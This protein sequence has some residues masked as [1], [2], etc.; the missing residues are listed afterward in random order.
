MPDFRFQII[1]IR[2]RQAE[3]YLY[4]LTVRRLQLL[5][6]RIQY[7]NVKGIGSRYV[8]ALLPYFSYRGFYLGSRNCT[9]R[10]LCIFRENTGIRANCNGNAIQCPAL[11]KYGILRLRILRSPRYC[12][13]CFPF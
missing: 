8:D 6:V 7:L 9:D 12:F 13:L 4:A 1:V 10:K 2:L 3:R 5:A 11:L